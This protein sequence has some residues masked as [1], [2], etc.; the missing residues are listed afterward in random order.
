MTSN[1][2]PYLDIL[3]DGAFKTFSDLPHSP[4]IHRFLTDKILEGI[5]V[6]GGPRCAEAVQREGLTALHRHFP[7]DY[8]PFLGQ[9]LRETASREF[10][11]FCVRV[12]LDH[13]GLEHDFYIDD[14]VALFLQYPYEVTKRSRLTRRIYMGLNLKNYAQAA[15]ELE[16]AYRQ[17]DHPPLN[18]RDQA[19]AAYQRD[20]PFVA[21][22]HGPHK[23]SWFAHSFGAVNVWYAV[24]GVTEKTGVI[25]YPET[26]GMDFP[27]LAAKYLCPGIALPK[28]TK[29][30][31]P[32]GSVLVFGP[33]MLHATHLNIDDVTRIVITGRLNPRPPRF[34]PEIDE[35]EH[36]RWLLSREVLAGEPQ[37][38][39]FPRASHAGRLRS[40]RARAYRSTRHELVVNTSL[41]EAGEIVVCRTDELRPGE[42]LLVSSPEDRVVVCRTQQDVYALSAVCPHV[43]INLVDGFHDEEAIYCPGHGVRY[44]LRTGRSE[45]PS[46]HLRSM[47]VEIRDGLVVLK[48]QAER[49]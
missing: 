47:P 40:H 4:A 21:W 11:R 33:D 23:D 30:A 7:V 43:G 49:G 29:M 17:P 28:P 37:V 12:G 9:F 2:A 46:L 15:E 10:C 24:C 41:R 14:E 19:K 26:Y 34:D 8:V 42:K 27:Y 45:C 18:E 31:I 6:I 48:R 16:R 25:L 22:V 5:R 44:D 39:L 32:D 20:L 1:T 38:R 36:P 13:L 35:A 3:D